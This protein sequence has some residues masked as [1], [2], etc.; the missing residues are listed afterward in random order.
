MTGQKII[1]AKEDCTCYLE[2]FYKN[3]AIKAGFSP[4]EKRARYDCRKIDVPAEVFSSIKAFYM[5]QG[6]NSMLVAAIW[7][8]CGPKTAC[9]SNPEHPYYAIIEDGFFT[10]EGEK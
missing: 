2:D 10:K 4:S 3:V 7:V 1:L 6:D 5:H 8:L 9:D